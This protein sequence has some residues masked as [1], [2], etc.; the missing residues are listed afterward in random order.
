[1]GLETGSYISALVATNPVAATDNV[2]QGDD[3]IRFIKAKLLETFAN[4]TGA[5]TS[6]HTE[7]N[8]VAGATGGLATLSVSF[9]ALQTLVGQMATLSASVTSADITGSIRTPVLQTQGG[10]TAGT[11]TAATVIVNSKGIVTGVTA[12]SVSNSVVVQVVNSNTGAVATGTTLVP[13]DDTIPQNTEGDEYLTA[14]ITPTS[15]TNKLLIQCVIQLATSAAGEMMICALFQDTTANSLAAEMQYAPS[16]GQPRPFV[17][18]HYMTA[19]T[20]SATTFK[21]RAGN[22]T[23][24][25]MTINGVAGARKLGGV[26]I[27]SITITEI[28]A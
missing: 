2:S 12:G 13:N 22:T 6:S 16:S 5:V 20:T 1:M 11:F 9:A 28:L 23:T 21:I 7:L 26:M 10:F 15:A 14:S 24:G 3:H 18:T 25:T 8:L 17:I 4:V 19:G 27:S